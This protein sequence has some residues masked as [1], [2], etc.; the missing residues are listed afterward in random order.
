MPLFD[1][2][3]NRLADSIGASDLTIRL[4][5]AAVF[6]WLTAPLAGFTFTSYSL[7]PN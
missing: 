1:T 4:H 2:E 5:T 3:L 7:C 6:A